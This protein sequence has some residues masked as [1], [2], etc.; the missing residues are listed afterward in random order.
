MVDNIQPEALMAQVR[1]N[2]K[3]AAITEGLVLRLSREAL[4][5]GLT[6]KAAVKSVRNKLHQVGGA[7]F[8]RN[9]NYTHAAQNLAELPQQMDAP[10]VRA[11]CRTLMQSHASTAERLP[12]LEDFY[13][14]CLAPLAPISSILDL[15]CGL[16]PL[17]LPWMP[18]ATGV[19]YHACDIYQD[20][21]GLIGSFFEHF[22]ISGTANPCDLVGQVPQEQAQVAL[23]LKSI[24]C[25][26]Q[27]DKRI[28]LAL[29]DAI[30][31]EHVLVSFPI[32][33]LGGRQK[34]MPAFYRNHFYDLVSGQPWVVREFEFATELAFL[35]TK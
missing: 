11:F 22:N 16:N 3:Y 33:S 35:V 20:M 25:L 13:T 26:E 6:G 24:P 12:V 7:Y 1:A 34:G 32:H 27:M 19:Q 28:A 31:A 9:I 2:P 5:S 18:V 14:T 4:A 21:L 30:K 23:L 10:E 15:A 17:S 8:K 29:L